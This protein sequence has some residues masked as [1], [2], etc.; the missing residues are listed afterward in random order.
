MQSISDEKSGM[1]VA[2]RDSMPT[3]AAIESTDLQVAQFSDSRLLGPYQLG[4]C[5][6]EGGMA[7]IYEAE[8]IRTG[9]LVAVKTV[10]T[11]AGYEIEALEREIATLADLRHPGVVRLI[12]AA[13]TDGLPWMAMDLLE[14]K[15]LFDEIGDIWRSRLPN[16]RAVRRTEDL[17]FGPGTPHSDW[18]RHL[19]ADPALSAPR[20]VAAAGR[21]R[22]AVDVILELAPILDYLHSRDVVHRDLKPENVILGPDGRITLLDF[23]MATS[24]RY[25]ATDGD[26]NRLC[27]ATVEYA[28]PELVC[29]FAADARADLYSLGCIFYELVTGR[30]P[31]NGSTPEEIAR[32]QVDL[33]PNCPTALVTG[34]SWR[35]EDL[36]MS[37]LA[38]NPGARP[39]SA[40][41]VA[42]RLS[43]LTESLAS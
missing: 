26:P 6:A 15:T 38:K 7:S 40:G 27:L 5:I 24:S 16:S 28:A 1:W 42:N 23:G 37:L 10:R 34:L 8:D 4:A 36:I 30:R 17:S 35:V 3:A 39:R 32:K 14:G 19:D 20:Q 9:Q 12:A 31:F 33:E 22:D 18:S 2:V 21:L 29:G 11:A 25:Q 43:R 41:E 13:R